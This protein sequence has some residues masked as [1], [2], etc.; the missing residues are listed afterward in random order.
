MTINFLCR[1]EDKI[2]TKRIKMKKTKIERREDIEKK[3]KVV[4]RM[5]ER[6]GTVIKLKL[7]FCLYVCN[8]QGICVPKD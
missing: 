7:Y 8:I 5:G 2:K 3:F 4:G 6:K 1:E